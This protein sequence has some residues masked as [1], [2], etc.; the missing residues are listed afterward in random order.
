VPLVLDP[1]LVAAGGARLAEEAL[2]DVLASQLYPLATLFH[3]W[4]GAT[5]VL[6]DP[7]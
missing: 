1:V 5:P 6:R 3:T 4:A 7:L 2:V